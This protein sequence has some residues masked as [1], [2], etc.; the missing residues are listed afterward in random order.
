[1]KQVLMLEDEPLAAN[2]LKNILKELRPDYKVLDIIGS[3]KKGISWIEKE[4]P[5]L[6]LSDIQLADGTCFEIFENINKEIP[7]IFITAYNQY[8]IQAFKEFSIDYLLKPIDRKELQNAIEK[9]EKLHTTMNLS[10]LVSLKNFLIERSELYQERFRV[11]YGDKYLAVTI[12]DIAY[13][14]SEDRYTYL[15]TKTGRQH[16]INFNLSELEKKLNPKD[17][18]RI[19]RKFIVKF[20][21][22]VN[23]TSHTK[24][25]VKLELDPPLPYSMEAIVSVEKSGDFKDWLNK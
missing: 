17:F 13:F 21:S 12:K 20:T 5:D 18:F 25:R 2:E 9:F 15:V 3:V 8:A 16:I 4:N 11:T 14:F 1:M 23:M 6:I 24:S 22:I 10:E 7:I 19:N